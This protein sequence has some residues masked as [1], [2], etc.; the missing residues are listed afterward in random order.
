[1]SVDL[2]TAD[3][4]LV[5]HDYK[6]VDN[7]AAIPANVLGTTRQFN[8]T[9]M[10]RAG[11]SDVKP[12]QVAQM[13][14]RNASTTYGVFVTAQETGHVF[15]LGDRDDAGPDAGEEVHSGS[16]ENPTVESLS[17]GEDEWSIMTRRWTDDRLAAPMNG[18]YFAF[19]LEELSTAETH[20]R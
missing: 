20:D 4:H 12:S 14:H 5:V 10:F 3:E 8:A 6:G 16:D 17:K 15:A 7:D 13:P 2:R 11:S 1:M 18:R 9:D 19:S